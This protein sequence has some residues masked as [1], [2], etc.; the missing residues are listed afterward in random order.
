[1]AI[2]HA[3]LNQWEELLAQT[4]FSFEHGTP[5]N[6]ATSN[7]LE[8]YERRI[9]MSFPHGYK[10]FCMVFGKVCFGNAWI[11]IY[12]PELKVFEDQRA[13]DEEILVVL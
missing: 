4:E 10:E 6:T 2:D 5:L 7:E 12:R 1:M 8:E 13:S 3:I 11:R 9:G